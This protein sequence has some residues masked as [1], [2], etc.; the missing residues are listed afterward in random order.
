MTVHRNVTRPL[1][2]VYSWLP[3]LCI[4]LAGLGLPARGSRERGSSSAKK[5]GATVTDVI[6]MTRWVSPADTS[7]F[8]G[9]SRDSVGLFSPDGRQFVVVLEKG[10]VERNTNDYSL[11][12]FQTREAF[13]KPKPRVLVTMSSSSNRAA[14]KDVKWLS[15]SKT[16]VFLG[17]NPRQTPEVYSFNIPTS[18][19]ARLTDHRTPIE[20][21]DANEDGS[22]IVYEADLPSHKTLDTEETR[23]NGVVITTQYVSDLLTGDCNELQKT[24]SIYKGLFVER[25]G[26]KPAKVTTRDFILDIFPVSISPDGHY[27]VLPMYLAKV[28]GSWSAY[29]DRLLHPYI[30]AAQELGRPS[31]VLQYML[32]DTKSLRITPLVD[33]PISWHDNGFSWIEAGTSVVLSGTYL[34]LDVAAIADLEARKKHTFV[35]EVNI[36][37]GKITEITG[38]ALSVASWDE[39]SRTLSLASEATGERILYEKKNSAWT[40]VKTPERSKI[41]VD[42]VDVRLE[43]DMN[44]PPRI[45]VMDGETRRK[46]LLLDLNPQFDRIQFGKVDTVEWTA[47]DGHEVAGELYLPANYTPGMR[48]PLVIQTHGFNKTRFLIDGPYSSAFAAQPLAATGFVVLQVGG[49]SHPG[50]DAQYMNTPEEAPRE[51]AAYEGAIDYLSERGLIDRS[52]VGLIG[53]S[54]TVFYVEYTLTHSKYPFVAAIVADG[55]D[56]GYMN[57][58]LWGGQKENYSSVMGGAPFGASLASWLTNSPGFNLDKVIAAVRI[59]YYGSSGPL[60]GWQAFSG[61]SELGKPVDF[62]WLPFGTHLLVKPWERFTSL[63]GSVDWFAFWL[64]QKENRSPSNT[65]QYARWE[66]L[67]ILRDRSSDVPGG[68]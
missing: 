7:G 32:L 27:A 30:V 47:T 42:A 62:V 38:A 5:R 56:G 36:P 12:L 20:A 41:N 2:G 35:A 50:E 16:L 45:F 24:A 64:S 22:V 3:L 49:S 17:E 6:Q 54:R 52:R 40:Q 15:D 59:E 57:S 28:P 67:R 10:N 34:P 29:E 18:H 26:Q 55:F 13:E 21:F 66:K 25:R 23:R 44:T 60:E 58:I 68:K 46:K 9:G 11:L 51:M 4:G 61:L 39:K 63:Q 33:A 31:N 1:L 19:L 48:Y 8:S 37:S 14:I 65:R 53:F 43:Q